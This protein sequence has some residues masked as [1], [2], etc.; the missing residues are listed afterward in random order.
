MYPNK[1][2]DAATSCGEQV[3]GDVF[4]TALQ[5]AQS[6]LGQQT[7]VEF[8]E[9]KVKTLLPALAYI[10]WMTVDGKHSYT[11][12]NHIQRTICDSYKVGYIF[13]VLEQ[14]FIF[15][16]KLIQGKDKPLDCFDLPASSPKPTVTIHYEIGHAASKDFFDNLVNETAV[17]NAIADITLVP[18]GRSTFVIAPVTTEP[19]QT[20]QTPTQTPT[21]NPTETPTQAPTQSPTQ[22][23]T[24]T[25][26]QTPVPTELTQTPTQNP[27]ETPTQAPTQNPTQT[28]TETPTQTPVPTEP[29]FLKRQ[30][31]LKTPKDTTKNCVNNNDCSQ[32]LEHVSSANLI[33]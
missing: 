29:I 26:A 30:N 10:P 20:T 4:S 6:N 27:T 31:G 21:Q 12:E 24:E 32:Y 5:C 28:P 11:I 14:Y 3:F 16:L 13:L 19:P 17:V 23:P 8:Y 2:V 33:Y 18:F 9:K 7:L 1:I 15:F 22:T 25:P